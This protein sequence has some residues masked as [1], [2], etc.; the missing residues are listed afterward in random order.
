MTAETKIGLLTG[1]S[2]IIV[3]AMILSQKGNGSGE[4]KPPPRRPDVHSEY[5][6]DS[7]PMTTLPR[8]AEPA[9]NDQPRTPA[10]TPAHESAAATT[11]AETRPSI[12]MS[13]AASLPEPFS[14]EHFEPVAVPQASEQAPPA[15]SEQ[16]RRQIQGLP[17]MHQGP[18]GAG[19]QSSPRVPADELFRRQP[20]RGPE[21]IYI[22]QA[23]DNLTRIA[24]RFLGSGSAVNVNRIYE[25]NRDTLP[26]KDSLMIGQKLRLPADAATTPSQRRSAD[27]PFRSASR[28]PSRTYTV[29]RG[30]T[31]VSIARQHLGHEGRWREIFNLNKDRHPDPDL[32]P[33][34]ATI[35]LPTEEV[36]LASR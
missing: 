2:V 8:A 6:A 10:P 17:P 31:Y 30:D 19:R 28:A 15:I 26:D 18:A 3:F 11:P 13:Q 1:L 21:R 22:A 35:K 9:P 5:I 4:S 32:L 23:N 16:L 25:L 34:G 7:V 24:A 27:A 20:T 14:P 36:R 33:A 29:R 12:G